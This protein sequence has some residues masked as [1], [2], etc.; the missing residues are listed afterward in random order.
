MLAVALVHYPTVNKEGRTVTTSV[1]NFDIHDIARASRTY[2]VDRYFIVTPVEL[3]RQF[4]RRI[5]AHWVAGPGGEYNPSRKDALAQTEV[6]SDLVEVGGLIARD[7]GREPLWVATSAKRWGHTITCKDLRARIK[8]GQENFCL[9]FGTG[10]GLH[11]E[12]L[13]HADMMLEPIN[14]PTEFNHLSVRS[15]VSIYLDRLL[16]VRSDEE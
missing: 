1:T 2:G 8:R 11:P 4:T 10:S 7:W 6:V 13:E 12:V 5:I 14:G 9:I 16:S 3:Q 15:A